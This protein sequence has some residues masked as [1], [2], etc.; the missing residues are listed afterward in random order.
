MSDDDLLGEELD[1]GELNIIYLLGSDLKQ[2]T[3]AYMSGVNL[4]VS[5]M[6]LYDDDDE[7]EYDDDDDYYYYDYDDYYNDDDDDDD[8]YE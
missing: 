5:V 1:S 6:Q 8:E 4:V 3:V 2:R 7:Y